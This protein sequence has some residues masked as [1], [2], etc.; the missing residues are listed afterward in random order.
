[1]TRSVIAQICLNIL[2]RTPSLPVS[3]YDRKD[4]SKMVLQDIQFLCAMGP[5]GGS[6]QE[7]TP[8]FVRH[9]NVVSINA[10]SGATMSRIF[11][12][13][14]SVYMRVRGS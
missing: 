8:R 4:C 6:R 1:M 11:T 2:S 5:P 14:L 10:F 3:R 12:T 7:V 9:F 13:L